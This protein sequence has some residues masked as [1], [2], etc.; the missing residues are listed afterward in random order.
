[1]GRKSRILSRRAFLGGAGAMVALPW[2]EAMVPS[3]SAF[4][5]TSSDPPTRLL[6]YYIPNGIHMP[7]WTPTIQGVGYDLPEILSPLEGL[8]DD[9]LVLTGLANLPGIPDGSGDH[10]GGTS[11]FLTCAHAK[12]TD[13]KEVYVGISVDQVAAEAIGS[14]TTFPSLQVG[15]QGATGAFDCDSGYSC[16]Y[17]Q[18]ITWAGPSTPL[19]KTV[20]PA[21]LFDRLFGGFDPLATAEQLERRR[22]LRLSVLDYVL[23]DAKKLQQQLGVT[24]QQKVEEYLDAV[25]ELELRVEQGPGDLACEP[26][27]RPEGGW[28]VTEHSDLMN[29]LMVK[30]FQCD[31]TRLISYMFGNAGSNR[32]YDFIGVS[33]AHHEISHHQDIQ[34]NFDKLTVIDTWEMVQFASL[35]SKL[36]A[37]PEGEGTLLDHCAVFLS[38]DVEDGNT[39]SHENLPVLLA[40]RAGG[41]IDPGRHVVYPNGPP[42]ANLYLQLLAAVGATAT[43]FGD[44]TGLLDGLTT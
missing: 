12:K 44:S 23:T 5:A 37:I 28:S 18:N 41:A 15:L 24:D 36:K 22:V 11:A 27:E 29:D 43:E 38:S 42:M 2:L 16:V 4:A 30:A 13:G 6:F 25:R 8:T 39:H 33:G 32:S 3:R 17:S 9:I 10:A 40:G 34:E 35:V 1:M 21:L 19:P 31:L 20:N 14:A 26:G 7:A